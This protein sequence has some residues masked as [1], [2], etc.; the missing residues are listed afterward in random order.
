MP[1]SEAQRRDLRAF[2]AVRGPARASEA[3]EH[4]GVSQATFSRLVESCGPDVLTIGRARATRYL[5]SRE[6]LDLGRSVPLFEVRED[7]TSRRLGTLHGV[8]PGSSFYFESLSDD[9]E[10][11]RHDDLPYF[12]EDLR[13]SGFLG[14]LV[15]RQHRDLAYPADIQLWT[16]NQCVAYLARF[17]WN[18]TGGLMAGEAAFRLYLE[19][20][21]A[22]RDVVE[23][24]ARPA[25]YAAL[26]EDV[27]SLG[28]PGSSAAGEQPK[29]LVSRGPGP[30][31]VLVKFS[32]PLID[33]VSRRVAD[34]LIAEWY[35]L[36]TLRAAGHPA[37]AAELLEAG[38]RIFLEVTRFDRLPAQGRRGLL[39]LR[40]LDLQFVGRAS[41]WSDSAAHL[42][43][44]R[45]IDAPMLAEIRWRELFGKLIANTD[46]HGGN[47]SFFTRGTRVVALAP[48]Y[49][50]A[51][52]LY[53]PAYSQLRTPPFDAPLP[54]A[55]DAPHWSATCAAASQLWQAVAADARVSPEF[56]ELAAANAGVVARARQL[57]RLLPE[58]GATTGETGE[59]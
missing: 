27:L 34:L 3:A 14:R 51:P 28:V 58:E 21:L 37:A 2:L 7:G 41:S 9:A 54:E 50:M 4:L 52:A 5:A 46:M 56:R 22:G 42:E 59:S 49:D 30:V 44:Q 40:A 1:S 17:G 26:A 38:N 8:L 57:Q 45:I 35:A 13:P 33:A 32:P 39:S 15:P 31:P 48:A 6:I 19:Q 43:R 12:L 20:T 11:G 55:A 53:A 25:R 16:G 36:E 24:A 23:P 47:L 18:L 10:S 29:F